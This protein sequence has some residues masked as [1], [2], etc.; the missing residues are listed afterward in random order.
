M[1]SPYGDFFSLYGW[2]SS[3]EVPIFSFEKSVED[4]EMSSGFQR[5]SSCTG[6]LWSAVTHFVPRILSDELHLFRGSELGHRGTKAVTLAVNARLP[7]LIRMRRPRF[8]LRAHRAL[9]VTPT[10]PSS[11]PSRSRS[12]LLDTRPPVFRALAQVAAVITSVSHRKSKSVCPEAAQRRRI[13]S[14]E[15]PRVYV[16]RR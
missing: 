14:V 9:L 3:Y 15:S 10:S 11:P 16:S 12:P 5:T 4:R 2:G 6:T 8:M 7:A 1:I 13:C